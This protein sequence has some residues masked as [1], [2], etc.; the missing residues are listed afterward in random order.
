MKEGKVG[1]VVHKNPITSEQMQQ[2]FTSGQLGDANTK[3]P[4]QLLRLGFIRPFTLEN[5]DE[6]ISENLPKR[7]WFCRLLLKEDGTMSSEEML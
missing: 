1:P 3:D 7:C 5:E 6:K 2:L 4:S